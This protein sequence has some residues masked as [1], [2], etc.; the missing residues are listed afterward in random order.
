MTTTGDQAGLAEF[1][2]RHPR[3]FV[4]TGAGCSTDSGIPDYRDADGEWRRGRP[5]MLQDFLGKERSRKRYWARSLV[6]FRR[7]RAAGPNDAHRALGEPRTSGADRAAR[8]PEHGR[9]AP[10]G[11]Q[12]KRDRISRAHR[13]R[14]LHRL[15]PPDAARAGPAGADPAQPRLRRTRCQ[16]GAGRRCRS[17]RRPVRSGSTCQPATPAVGC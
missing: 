10:G 16:R 13:H 4:L 12:S 17:R 8:H 15:R 1:I 5:I 6:G 3:L 2:A 14:A 11:R 9:P 7:M